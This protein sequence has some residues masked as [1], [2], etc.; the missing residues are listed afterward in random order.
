[1]SRP[2]GPSGG[3]RSLRSLSMA[4]ES[5][6][7]PVAFPGRRTC[8]CGPRGGALSL[9]GHGGEGGERGSPPLPSRYGMEVRVIATRTVG[10]AE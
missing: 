6:Q 5:P 8:H 7:D 3:T 4:Y 2:A 1:M 10:G 9:P